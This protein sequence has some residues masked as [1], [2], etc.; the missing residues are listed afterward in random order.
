MKTTN[1]TPCSRGILAHPR[2][3]HSC[4]RKPLGLT[5]LGSRLILRS[6]LEILLRHPEILV[7][8]ENDINS[9]LDYRSMKVLAHNT[10]THT[11]SNRLMRSTCACCLS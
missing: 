1:S 11:L 9:V 7:A 10:H 5:V 8:H 3:Q 2:S 6:Q 4:S